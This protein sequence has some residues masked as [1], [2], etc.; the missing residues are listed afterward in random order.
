M[1]PFIQFKDFTFKYDIQAEPTLKSLNLTIEKG[2]K[3]LI[4]G[5][6]GSGKS[7]I[8]HCLNGI[9]PNIYHGEKSG[10]FTI[11]GK[12]A[13]GLSIYDKSHLVSTVL[14]DPDGQF[15]G[16]TVAED[17]AFALENDCVSL[18]EMQEKVAHWAK[19]LDLTEFLDNRPQDLSGGQKQRV[20][21]AGVLID[22]S[23]ILLFDEPLANL[24]PKS[25]QETID[26]ID[27]IHHEEKA[28]TIIIEHRL[29]DVLYRHVDKVVLVNDGQILFD[30]HPDELLRTE[31][32]IQNGIREPLYVTAL[33]DLGVDVTSMEHLSDLSQID[34]TNIAVTAP[35]SFQE[36][37]PQDK[38]LTVEQLHFAYQENRPILKN[39]N[40][41]INQGERIAIVGKNGAG[42][43]TL[44]KAICQFIT[45]EGDIRYRGQSIMTDSIKE[46][47]EKIGYVLQN[48]NQ[49]ISQTMIFDEVALGLRL[50]GVDEQDVEKRVLETLKVCG[51]YEF[52]KW[53]ISA[54]S[55]G[56]KKRVTIASVLVMNPEI[57]LLDEPTAGQDKRNYTE[58]MNFLN[59][60][61]KA[62]HTI[63]MIT[64]DMQLMLEYSDRSIVVSNGEII[65][66]CSPVAL[67]NQNAILEKANL[68]KTSLFEL[69]EKLAVDPIALT[70]Y[71]IEKE[72]GIHG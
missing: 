37:A 64:H 18:E 3:V 47:A 48:P 67:F 70:H 35:S 60:L 24:D 30:G 56:Q 26:L 51:L 23:P 10:Q 52:R 53:P 14:Q 28:T 61:N 44:A 45:P 55:F 33:K 29:E 38:L 6:S 25:G 58:I 66:D 43:S 54:L 62:G 12:E 63:I 69:A 11:D 7:T 19:R 4:I 34:L 13:F 2:Q 22:E 31:L 36:E 16:L 32:L 9:I 15:I 27:R 20:S 68:K 71:Y 65:A 57:I 42:K 59:Q 5:P 17:L 49:M 46:R 50:R 21:L 40:F 41:E 8:G 72:G 39:I 1:K